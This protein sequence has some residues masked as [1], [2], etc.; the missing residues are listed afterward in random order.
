MKIL[1]TN[2][3]F[4]KEFKRQLRLAIIAAIGFT[5]AFAWR[6]A[7]FDTFQSFISRIFALAPTHFTTEIYTAIT[8]TLAGVAIIFLTSKILK[9]K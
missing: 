9:D 7:I 1:K 2:R 3:S 4:R 5:V 6:N 8:I